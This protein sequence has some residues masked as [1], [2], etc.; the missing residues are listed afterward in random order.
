MDINGKIEINSESDLI[1]V[2]K[3]ARDISTYIGFSITDVTRIVTAVSE[4]ARNIYVYARTGFMTWQVIYDT[5]KA[6]IEFIFEDH[7]PG[8]AD[9][10]K[11]LEGGYSTGNGLGLGVSGAKRLMDDIK[12]DTVIGKGTKISIKKWSRR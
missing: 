5:N 12:I 4:L 1:A 11:V 8:I 6:G 7:G 2:R 10:D 9:L 3:A